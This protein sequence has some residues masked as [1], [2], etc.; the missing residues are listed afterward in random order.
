MAQSQSFTT[1]TMKAFE[2]VVGKGKKKRQVPA[3]SLF[4]MMFSILLKTTFNFWVTFILSSANAFNLNWAKLKAFADDK[5]DVT[6][7]FSFSQ[8][9]SKD[10]FCGSLKVRVVCYRVKALN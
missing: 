2:N 1:L 9:V 7:I 5:S 3:F 8:N 10:L 6:R 4:P